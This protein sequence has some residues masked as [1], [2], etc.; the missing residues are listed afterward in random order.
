MSYSK[1]TIRAAAEPTLSSKLSSTTHRGPQMVPNSARS[2][3][4]QDRLITLERPA[5]VVFRPTSAGLVLVGTTGFE[6][7]TP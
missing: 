6:P 4:Q 1:T 5:D 2:P 7:A 3:I